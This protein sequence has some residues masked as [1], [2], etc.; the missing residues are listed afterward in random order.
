MEGL[1]PTP[2]YEIAGLLMLHA[3]SRRASD[4]WLVLWVLGGLGVLR[5]VVGPLRA[6]PVLGEPTVPIAWIAGAWLVLSLT[7]VAWR[8]AGTIAARG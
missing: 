1:H 6:A 8:L 7:C 3:A 4:R 2:L 5:L